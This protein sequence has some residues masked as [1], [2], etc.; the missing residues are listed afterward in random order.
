MLDTQTPRGF[1]G[2]CC[3]KC[4]ESDCVA[5]DLHNLTGDESI[6]CAQCNTSFGLDDVRSLINQWQRVLAWVA[7]APE[8]E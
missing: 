5:I 7:L 4:G 1:S 8:Q 3:I 2:I 6:S